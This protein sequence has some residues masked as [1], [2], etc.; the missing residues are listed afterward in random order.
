M[1]G[2]YYRKT[3]IS[4]IGTRLGIAAR[5]KMV[6]LFFK[7]FPPTESLTV[8]DLGVTSENDPTANFLEKL[9]PNLNNLT[10]AGVQDSSWLEKEYPGIKFI[11]IEQG[12]ALP[13]KN[14]EFDV[15]Y[16]NAVIEHVGSRR[17]QAAFIAEALRVGKAFFI[18]TPN[19]WFPVETHTHIPLLHYLPQDVFRSIL[20]LIG[21]SFYSDEK[22]LNL[23]SR[24]D[25]RKTF[26]VDTMVEIRFVR[27]AGIPSNIVAHG[28]SH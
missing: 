19:R 21:E 13:F 27:T 5:Q 22:N 15:V 24:Q 18:T 16:S 25:L 10:C 4:K 20:R 6:E 8:L 12:K 23:L 3:V 17:D 11:K 9:Y 1:T 7:T 14:Q 2:I 26:P 28:L